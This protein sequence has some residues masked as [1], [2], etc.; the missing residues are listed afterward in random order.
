VWTHYFQDQFYASP[1]IADDMVYF[2]DRSGV[3]HI[4]KAGSSFRLIAESPL[5]E[6]ADCSPAFSDRKIYIR[7]K[8]NLY[9]ISEN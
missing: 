8:K 6:S 2:L 3:M 9:C 7:G 4:V 1:V 5:G